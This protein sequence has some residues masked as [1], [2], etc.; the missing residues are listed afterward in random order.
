LAPPLSGHTGAVASV[1]FSPDGQ[2]VASGSDDQTIRFWTADPAPNLI[3]DKLTANMSHNQW[4]DWVSP[5]IGYHAV[6]PGLPIPPG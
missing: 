5:V 2:R 1:A 3:C 4:S 6:C